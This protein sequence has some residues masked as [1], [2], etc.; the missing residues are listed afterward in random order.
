MSIIDFR[1][2]KQNLRVYYTDTQTRKIWVCSSNGT[3]VVAEKGRDGAAPRQKHPVHGHFRLWRQRLRWINRRAWY[4][5]SKRRNLP[6]E[7]D[8][9]DVDSDPVAFPVHPA[10]SEADT[11]STAHPLPSISSNSTSELPPSTST[12]IP[13]AETVLPPSIA[14]PAPER[15]PASHRVELHLVSMTD[16]CTLRTLLTLLSAVAVNPANAWLADIH[17]RCMQGPAS[18]VP[19]QIP[20]IDAIFRA[21]LAKED[22]IPRISK[23]PG[24]TLTGLVMV[25]TATREG[26]PP[27]IL[28]ALVDL[29]S[30]ESIMFSDSTSNTVE[31]DVTADHFL[32][33]QLDFGK[34]VELPVGHRLITTFDIPFT[35]GGLGKCR[36]LFVPFEEGRNTILGPIAN[37][38]TPAGAITYPHYDD[39]ACGMYMIHWRGEKVWLLWPGTEANL[40]HMEFTHTMSGDLTTTLSLID[41]LEGLHILF[42]TEEEFSEYAFYLRITTIH[43]CISVTESCHAGRPVRT[44]DLRFL[45]DLEVAYRCATDWMTHRLLNRASVDEERKRELVLEMVESINHWVHL[46]EQLPRGVARRGLDKVLDNTRAQLRKVAQSLGMFIEI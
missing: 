10:V 36:W 46:G 34:A 15:P 42:L 24:E 32:A 19:G 17:N 39:F 26:P 2:S 18:L 9:E 40:R 3:W 35:K 4:P 16:C 20:K 44:V 8:D 12:A 31:S 45:P 27:T 14:I 38:W 13:S 33:Q 43:C 28:D 6:A 23:N 41:K 1:V 30:A 11:S 5:N 25:G 29:R 22:A 37:T 7:T 21:L